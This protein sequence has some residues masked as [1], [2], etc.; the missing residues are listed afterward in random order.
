MDTSLDTSLP[1][2][3]LETRGNGTKKAG[4]DARL[5]ATDNKHKLHHTTLSALRGVKMVF[6]M[7][8]G[9]TPCVFVEG[10]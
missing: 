5:K 2:Y 6:C 8:A 1:K 3:P 9:G 4:A 7:I 10:W